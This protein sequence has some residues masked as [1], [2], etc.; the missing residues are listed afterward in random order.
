MIVKAE[1]NDNYVFGGYTDIPWETLPN[2]YEY[3]RGNHKSFLFSLRDIDDPE[4]FYYQPKKTETYHMS[5]TSK[6]LPGFYDAWFL[7]K[8]CHENKKS[9]SILGM[10]KPS[11][12]TTTNK[13][14]DFKF[15]PPQSYSYMAGS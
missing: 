9:Y 14:N 3:K 4:K 12:W 5:P 8:N 2:R 13:P 11:I 15:D 1:G 10:G 7:S 6:W